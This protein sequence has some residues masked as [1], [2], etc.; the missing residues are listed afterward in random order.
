MFVATHKNAILLLRALGKC[1]LVFPNG[2]MAKHNYRRNGDICKA[3]WLLPLTYTLT[4]SACS[5]S[6]PKKSWPMS[7]KS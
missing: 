7:S 2:L 3:T 1:S 6:I 4:T 5:T